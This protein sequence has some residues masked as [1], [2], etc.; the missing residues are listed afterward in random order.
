MGLFLNNIRVT[1]SLIIIELQE[2]QE[3]QAVNMQ[4][5]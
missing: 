2:P 5:T 3:V 4:I 1:A